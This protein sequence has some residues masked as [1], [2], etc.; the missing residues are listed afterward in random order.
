[1]KFKYTI[2][3]TTNVN[4]HKQILIIKWIS[5]THDHFK[6][7]IDGTHSKDDICGGIDEVIRDACGE[8]IIGFENRITVQ[9]H[10]STKLQDMHYGLK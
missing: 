6:L 5:P 3:I 10:I 7:N 1:M 9:N 4:S 2:N 8:W